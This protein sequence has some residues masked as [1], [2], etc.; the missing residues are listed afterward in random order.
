MSGLFP[1][2]PPHKEQFFSMPKIASHFPELEKE[3]IKFK[4]VKLVKC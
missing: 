1:S 2:P 4:W 3:K